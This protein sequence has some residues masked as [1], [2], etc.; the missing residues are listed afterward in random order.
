MVIVKFEDPVV[1]LVGVA[2][3]HCEVMT[4]PYPSLSASWIVDSKNAT[5]DNSISPNLQNYYT[6]IAKGLNFTLYFFF[7]FS[8]VFK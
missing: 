7:I 4:V 2:T 6:K 1:D 3:Q 5:G 8:N